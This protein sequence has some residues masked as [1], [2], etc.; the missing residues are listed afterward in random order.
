MWHP[1][2]DEPAGQQLDEQSSICQSSVGPAE[3]SDKPLHPHRFWSLYHS[4]LSFHTTL[5]MEVSRKVRLLK[6]SNV[7]QLCNQWVHLKKHKKGNSYFIC[8]FPELQ[9]NN[10][11]QHNSLDRLTYVTL[12]IFSDASKAVPSRWE[13]GADRK[14]CQGHGSWRNH[15]SSNVFDLVAMCCDCRLRLPEYC[16]GVHSIFHLEPWKT[17]W[18]TVPLLEIL[19]AYFILTCFVSGD[20]TWMKTCS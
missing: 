8:E 11:K 16:Y 1:C 2:S 9:K 13:P 18:K 14:F 19:Q 20:Y 10:F 12:T 15:Q 17:L 7:F 4:G 3:N 6:S 5:V